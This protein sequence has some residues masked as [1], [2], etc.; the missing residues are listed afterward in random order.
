MSSLAV[1]SVCRTL[2][3]TKKY[4][5]TGRCKKTNKWQ[6]NS[7]ISSVFAKAQYTRTSRALE[8]RGQ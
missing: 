3:L 8:Q 1:K 7:S 2:K 6:K 4:L 5:F